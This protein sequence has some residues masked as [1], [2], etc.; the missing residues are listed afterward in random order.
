MPDESEIRQPF[1]P[2]RANFTREIGLVR[3]KNTCFW[4][5]IVKYQ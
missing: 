5:D 3:I 4:D 1:V 2:Y